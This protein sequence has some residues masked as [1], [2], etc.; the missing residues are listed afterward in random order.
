MRSYCM[1]WALISYDWRPYR[2]GKFRHGGG[3][4]QRECHLKAE[5]G[6]IKQKP[7]TSNDCWQPTRN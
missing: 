5:T 2:K 4:T 1:K 3:Y 7:N 6:V